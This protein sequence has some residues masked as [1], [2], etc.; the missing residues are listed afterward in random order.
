MFDVIKTYIRY[1][2]F[3]KNAVGVL[4]TFLHSKILGIVQT[5]NCAVMIICQFDPYGLA[6][7]P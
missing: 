2:I 4:Q 1:L 5:Y 7:G 6:H 3:E